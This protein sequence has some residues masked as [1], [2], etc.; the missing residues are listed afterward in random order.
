[1]IEAS[2]FRPYV[3]AGRIAD[4]APVSLRYYLPRE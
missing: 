1:L 2:A 3:V 4:S